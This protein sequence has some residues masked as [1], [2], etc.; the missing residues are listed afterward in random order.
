MMKRL[1]ALVLCLLPMAAIAQEDD[2]SY[3]AGLLEGY[4]SDAGR[5]V[6]ITG[7]EGALSSRATLQEMT[8]ADDAGVW[9]T[10]RDVSLDWSRAALLRGEVSV[11]ELTAGEIIVA[12]PPETATS[13]SLPA[14][15]ASGFALPDLPV[16]INIGKLAATRIELGAP[17]LGEPF[18]EA[19]IPHVTMFKR[20]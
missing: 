10:L 14:A 8:I 9:L 11:N 17:L 20:L 15:E 4:L 2:K 16:S 18:E 5:A 6:T 1:F 19:G 12:R 13:D 7:F 3:L